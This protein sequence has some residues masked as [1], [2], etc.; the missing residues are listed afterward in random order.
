LPSMTM[1]QAISSAL[2]EEMGKD[3]R[4]IVLGEDV[5]KN[6]G[7]FRATEGLFRDFGDQRVIDTP[8]SESGI[9]GMS[10]GLALYGF[11]PVAEIQ[12]ADFV[13]PGFDQIVSELAKLRYRSGGEYSAPVVLRLPSGGGIKGGPYHSQSIESFFAHIPGLKVVTPSSPYNAKGLIK[14]AIRDSDPVVFL[15]PKR[16]YRTTRE[17]VPEEEYSVPIGE[18]RVVQ[19]GADLTVI[20]YGSV[21]PAAVDAATRLGK[22]GRVSVELIDLQTLVPLDVDTI[23]RSVRKTGRVVVAY[24]APKFMGFGAEIAAMIAE[25]ALESLEAPILRVGGFDTPFPY[26]HETK[27]M[28]GAARIL[29][30]AE[31]LMSY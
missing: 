1:V 2:H 21:V 15:E 31:R 14:S 22:E 9:I 10:I 7:V 27:Y 30:A 3:S 24:E 13:Y 20:A 17:D 4:V 23:L 28:P 26:A 18:A 12:F 19:E 16:L 8:L 6:G 25:E 11:R 29:A 5:G